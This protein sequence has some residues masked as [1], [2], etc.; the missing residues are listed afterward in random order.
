MDFESFQKSADVKQADW[1]DRSKVRQLS[2]RTRKMVIML[3]LEEED[4]ANVNH[5]RDNIINE[6]VF[7]SRISAYRRKMEK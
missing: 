2:S 4:G 3:Q 6:V 1:K 7:L 5:E